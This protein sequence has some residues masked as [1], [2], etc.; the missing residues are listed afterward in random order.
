MLETER[1]KES[2]IIFNIIFLVLIP[3]SYLVLS[4]FENCGAY[5]PVNLLIMSV[6]ALYAF[7]I[8]L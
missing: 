7:E 5:S 3:L 4:I 8:E 6:Y 1:R 2:I